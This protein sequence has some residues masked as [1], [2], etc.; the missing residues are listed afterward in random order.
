MDDD[1]NIRYDSG[2]F[3]KAH[4]SFKDGCLIFA[5]DPRT[6]LHPIPCSTDLKSAAFLKANLLQL[7][8][9]ETEFTK[10]FKARS[11]SM[12]PILKGKRKSTTELAHWAV[13][14]L[15]PLFFLWNPPWAGWVMVGY[16]LLAS[17]P[18]IVAQRYNRFRLRRLLAAAG[19][20]GYSAS[21]SHLLRLKSDRRGRRQA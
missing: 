18:F 15:A 7:S 14:A 9:N 13:I 8:F 11:I 3:H 6:K 1:F 21:L 17:A 10:H 19:S 4:V 12:K 16:A 20:G 5:N 2:P